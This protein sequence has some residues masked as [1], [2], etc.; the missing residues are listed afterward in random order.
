[1]QGK[2]GKSCKKKFSFF[3]SLVKSLEIFMRTMGK[4]CKM[5]VYV[6]EFGCVCNFF[7]IFGHEAGGG[8]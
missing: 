6:V 5:I 3:P 4:S 1:M 7:C 2:K 8:G